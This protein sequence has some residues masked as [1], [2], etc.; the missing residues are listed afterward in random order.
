MDAQ[1]DIYQT[2]AT[3][4]CSRWD[5]DPCIRLWP[6]F[7]TLTYLLCGHRSCSAIIRRWQTTACLHNLNINSLRS[8]WWFS[9]TAWF[10]FSPGH[11]C[12][13]LRG[14]KPICTAWYPFHH[15]KEIK[16]TKT[17]ASLGSSVGGIGFE[18]WTNGLTAHCS[19]KE[20]QTDNI[21]SRVSIQLQSI[22]LQ[23][24]H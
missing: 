21:I 10:P 6:N 9:T 24:H 1:V 12:L 5:D 15:P 11:M 19:T 17:P 22:A 14:H 3:R 18:R 7:R 16:Y 23:P 13:S 2:F 8:G 4:L 20:L